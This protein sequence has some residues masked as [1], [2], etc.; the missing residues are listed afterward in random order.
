MK[1][2]HNR[3]AALGLTL[4]TF[5]ACGGDSNTD[6]KDGDGGSSSS[7]N[8]GAGGSGAGTG[9]GG[10]QAYGDV[11]INEIMYNPAAS[12]DET[13]EWVELY[14]PTA[15]VIDLDG[16]ILRDNA[17]NLHMIAG[18]TIEPGG[19]VVL[20]RSTSANGGAPVDQAY[21]DSFKL[22]NGADAVMLENPEGEIVDEVSYDAVAP[23]PA[24]TAGVSIELKA[25]ALDNTLAD[26]WEHA[27]L[28]FGDGDLGTPGRVNGGTV[29]VPGFDVDTG[30]V[31]WHQPALKTSVHFAPEDD[32]EGHVLAH[33][34]DAQTSI[35][36]AF[37]NIRLDAVKD[38]LVQKK[39]AGVAVHVVLD[40]KQQDKDYNTMGE[41]L[42]AL[43]ITVTLV[44]NTSA[45]DAT[46]HNKFAI[47]DG[48]LVMTGSANYSYTALNV[49]DEDLITFDD[50]GL[51]ARY[52]AEFAELI[53]GG[54]EDSAPYTGAPAIQAWMGPE[55]NL[56]YKVVGAIDA[57]QNNVTVAM[58][59]LNTG[60]IVDALIAAHQ[61]GVNVVVILDEAQATQVDED[62]DEDLEAAGVS[63]ILADATGGTAAEMHSKF[64]VVDHTTVVMGSYNWTNLGSFYNDEN[65]L[66]I[67][68]A[69][70]AARVEGKFADLLTT[71]N[72]TASSLGLTT[73]DQ[74]VT[75]SVGNVTL[76]S[77]LELVVK[78]NGPL[79]TGVALVNGSATLNVAAGTRLTY[80]YE[81]RQA[82]STV[83]TE[84]GTHAFT[85]PYA[86]GPFAVS[87]AYVQ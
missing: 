81:V 21:G 16:W 64:V 42:V 30:A 76:E 15:S 78:G 63:V 68:D 12:S 1:L 19:Y 58:F 50:A 54:D 85:V 72:T 65:I 44:E 2:S 48:H 29:Q 79:A 75:F 17:A 53:A 6:F 11:V 18:L 34:A 24:D 47:I 4:A 51:A 46:M 62:A 40:K 70:L 25:F 87:D 8:V 74:A 43:G 83:A 82:G 33:L 86:P 59:Q 49:S 22:S 10:G 37:F 41:D 28:P 73:G 23:W 36:L 9:G 67:S 66:V 14:N 60:M 55:D 52:T 57:A 39:N 38:L 5:I 56:A 20:G 77:G 7:S 31:S 27:V 3:Y 71:Y 69:H 26:S 32:L 13:G 45:T 84:T 80:H 35:E 61:R